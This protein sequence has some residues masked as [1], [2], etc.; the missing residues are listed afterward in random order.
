MIIRLVIHYFL[1]SHII[2]K[3]NVFVDISLTKAFFI[4]N[5]SMTFH[6]NGFNNFSVQ[7]L[8]LV[9]DLVF[10]RR[11]NPIRFGNE[12]IWLIFVD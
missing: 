9:F 7:Y 6:L 12:L 4:I 3:W 10:I 8:P 5:I 11:N 2:N 1:L